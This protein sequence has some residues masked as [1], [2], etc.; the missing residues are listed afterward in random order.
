M[1][2][3]SPQNVGS[4]TPWQLLEAADLFEAKYGGGDG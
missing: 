4:L 3:I 1:P 2:A